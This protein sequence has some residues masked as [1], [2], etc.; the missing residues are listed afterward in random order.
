[1]AQTLD[2]LKAENAA[3]ELT[4]QDNQVDDKQ[5]AIKDE[6]VGVTE[7]PEA[8]N[9]NAQLQDGDSE[10]VELESWQLTEDTVTSDDDKKDGFVPNHEAARR[11]KKAKALSVE[12]KSEKDENAILR[13][14]LEDFE[15]GTA[16]KAQEEVKELVRP[17]REQFD[18]DDDAYDEAIEIYHDER[19]DRKLKAR[20]SK[21]QE[22]TSEANRQAAF[23]KKAEQSFDNHYNDAQTLIEEGKITEE[24]FRGAETL[25]KQALEAANPGRGDIAFNSLIVGL[26]KDSAK[27]EFQLGVNPALLHELQNLQAED[28][29]GLSASRFLGRL[30]EKIQAPSKKRS[31]APKPG[32]NAQGDGS[33]AGKHAPLLAEYRK[34]DDLQTRMTLKRKAKSQGADV[35]NW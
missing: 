14:R 12:L 11:R 34:S 10:K 24:S 18:Y 1:M 30:Q 6:H 32:T 25:V 23:Q 3:A 15:N 31:N 35:S 5:E 2:E 16:H 28:P 20:D 33:S 29:S 13:K 22:S 26:G 4:A 7:E 17:T 27:V 19:L 9:T 21:A 8:D